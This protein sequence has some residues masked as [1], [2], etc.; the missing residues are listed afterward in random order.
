[1]YDVSIFT[2]SFR[3]TINPAKNFSCLIVKCYTI[4]A[5]N[6]TLMQFVVTSNVSITLCISGSIVPSNV[7]FSEGGYP[8]TIVQCHVFFRL[9]GKNPRMDYILL[10]IFIPLSYLS[11]KVFSINTKNLFIIIHFCKLVHLERRR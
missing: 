5:I 9:G 6:K 4:T 10:E 8:S 3:L 7:K 2:T 1:M 11:T